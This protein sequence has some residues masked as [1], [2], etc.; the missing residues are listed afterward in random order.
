ML[1][2][3]LNFLF[4]SIRR[5]VSSGFLVVQNKDEFVL[6]HESKYDMV[7]TAC[8]ELNK[9]GYTRFTSAMVYAYLDGLVEVDNVYKY[10]N[11]LCNKGY[12]FKVYSLEN[13]KSKLKYSI[14]WI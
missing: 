6:K 4:G 8:L 2:K 7:K 5:P 11:R 1:R 14:K 12:I 3:I 9:A 10:I 13:G